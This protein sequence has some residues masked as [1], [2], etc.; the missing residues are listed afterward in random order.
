MNKGNT[1]ETG[2][3]RGYLSAAAAY[4]LWGFLPFYWKT[5][6]HVP[7][8]QVMLNRIVWCFVFLLIVS[9]FRR[10]NP[11]L[12]FKNLRLFG[13]VLLTGLILSVNWFVYIFSVNSGRIVEASLGYYI[14]PLVS[15]ILG[16]IFFRERLNR[17]QVTALI[18]AAAGVL[19]MTI[20]YGRFP[21]IALILAVTFGFYGLLKKYFSFDSIDGLMA[22]TF[23]VTPVAV[24]IL[25]FFTVRG[26]NA[27]FAGSLRDDIFL[28]LSGVATG[29]PLYFFGE[30]AKRI[31]L[32]AMGF[33][34]YIAPTLM[35][36]TG[37]LYYREPFLRAH[38]IGFSLIWTGLAV[39]T[40]SL[41]KRMKR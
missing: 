1:K 18:L 12:Y 4:I 37:I 31:P 39:Y 32:S 29:I 8:F 3:M 35:L 34:Q 20:D 16:M 22:E 21:Y 38:I 9:A 28:I 40:Y 41:I 24:I 17:L 26:E 5:L 11:F 14:N 30:G 6:H 15:I 25:I 33:L 27:L 36:M 2:D 7:S 19:Y 23:A 10:R 13:A